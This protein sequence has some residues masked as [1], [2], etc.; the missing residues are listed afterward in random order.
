MHADDGLQINEARGS[1]AR[2]SEGYHR[3]ARIVYEAHP[4]SPGVRAA[5]FYEKWNLP[6]G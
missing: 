2:M 6:K 4:A 1:F 3:V 5:R